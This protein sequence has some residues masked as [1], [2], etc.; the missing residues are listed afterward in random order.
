MKDYREPALKKFRKLSGWNAWQAEWW[1][2]QEGRFNLPIFK[3]FKTN[4]LICVYTSNIQ[5]QCAIEW[6]M[7]NADKKE[8]YFQAANEIN[9]CRGLNKT[10]LIENLSRRKAELNK[11]I[12]ELR[13]IVNILVKF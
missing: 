10:D 3:N 5:M 4:Y 12:R 9:K 13:K 11:Q 1:K 6:N 7:L 2:G 8:Q